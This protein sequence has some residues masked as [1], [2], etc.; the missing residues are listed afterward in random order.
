MVAFGGR[1][2][3]VLLVLALA[4]VMTKNALRF[5]AGAT[6]QL[7]HVALLAFLLPALVGIAGVMFELGVFDKLVLR[8]IE[9]KGSAN[10]R[11]VM[12]ELFRGFTIPELL[13]GPQQQNLAHYVHIYRL[14][15]GIESLWVAFIL[16]YGV[17]PSL[18]FFTGLLFYLFALTARCQARAWVVIGYFFI[19]NTTFLG[20]A[21]KTISFAMMCLFL[22]LLLPRR[23]PRPST[24]P[25]AP[26]GARLVQGGV[27]C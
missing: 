1:A 2:S 16:F 22:L 4:V 27:R 10:A 5:F 20:I 26:T 12:F 25:V 13:F 18:L 8:F 6:L 21:G 9:D 7:R 17:L 3:L 15:F 11:I 23:A 14:E 19:V 24:I